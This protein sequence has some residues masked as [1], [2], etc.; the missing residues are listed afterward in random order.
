M[1]QLNLNL[2]EHACSSCSTQHIFHCTSVKHVCACKIDDVKP[3]Y[4]NSCVHTRH[5][6][7]SL[8]T[9]ACMSGMHA[10]NSNCMHA[11]CKPK[12]VV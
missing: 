3:I 2:T 4:Q 8:Q 1:V 7:N 9:Y 12:T 5:V 11:N 10:P 6:H